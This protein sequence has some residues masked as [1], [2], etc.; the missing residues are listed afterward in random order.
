MSKNLAEKLARL[1]NKTEIFC[2]LK[3]Y[4]LTSGRSNEKIL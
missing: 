4:K 1:L 2:T 3:M